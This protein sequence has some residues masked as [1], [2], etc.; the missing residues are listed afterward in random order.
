M[1]NNLRGAKDAYERGVAYLLRTQQ[2]DG[3]WLV[4]SRAFPFQPYMESGFPH[5]HNQWISSAATAWATMAILNT[6]EPDGK[7]EREPAGKPELA[8]I[9]KAVR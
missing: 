1:V 8:V 7:R 5:G 2:E 3:S 4:Q 6:L 9:R